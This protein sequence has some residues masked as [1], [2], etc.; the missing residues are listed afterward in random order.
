MMQHLQWKSDLNP[1]IVE[2]IFIY[3]YFQSSQ[4]N[5]LQIGCF[6]LISHTCILECKNLHILFLKKSR[7]ALIMQKNDNIIYL[8]FFLTNMCTLPMSLE[9]IVLAHVNKRLDT[10]ALRRLLW[11]ETPWFTNHG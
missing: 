10:A 8:G 4:K 11:S 9:L 2:T 1:V 3:Y 5:N 7:T 6:P